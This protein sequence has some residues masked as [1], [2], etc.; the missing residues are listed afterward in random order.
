M[1]RSSEGGSRAGWSGGV[2]RKAT[3]RLG[4][5]NSPEI[6]RLCLGQAVSHLMESGSD[7]KKCACNAGDSGSIPGS[8]RSPGEGN[9]NPPILQYSCLE[10]PMDRGVW[11]APVQGVTESQT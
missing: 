6:P 8:G 3:P 2:G 4:E 10:N 11:W 7:S 9:G 5:T 1:M